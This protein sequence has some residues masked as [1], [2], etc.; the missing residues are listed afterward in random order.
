MPAR[1][2]RTRAKGWTMP[3]GAVYVGRPTRWGNPFPVAGSWIV[4]AAVAAGFR[5]DAAGRREASV[6]FHRR[7]LGLEAPDGG[8]IDTRRDE[9]TLANGATV[10]VAEWARMLGA[11]FANLYA[12]ELSLPPAPRPSEIAAELRGRD[13]AC[14]CP[15]HAPCHADTLLEIANR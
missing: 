9:L 8:V 11:S 13:L 7:W 6:A 3:A 10:A 4:W 1:I 14:W 5:A 2:Q 15:L 12:D